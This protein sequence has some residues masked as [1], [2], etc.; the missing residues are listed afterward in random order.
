MQMERVDSSIEIVDRDLDNLALLHNVWVDRAVDQRVGVRC[1]CADRS[2]QRR[3]F[4]SDV[5]NV[6]EVCSERG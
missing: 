4:L 5:C 1:P 3:H 6:V 2:E